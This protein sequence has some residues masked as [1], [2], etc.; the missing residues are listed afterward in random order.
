MNICATTGSMM[1]FQKF[2]FTHAM[3]HDR[4]GLMQHGDRL[5]TGAMWRAS[6]GAAKRQGNDKIY[7]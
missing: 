3:T 6:K 5:G 7:Q 2:G 4:L 1:V